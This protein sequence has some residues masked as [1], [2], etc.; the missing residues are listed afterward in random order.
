MHKVA[1]ETK[2]ESMK[3]VPSH[4]TVSSFDTKRI[5]QVIT[6]LEKCVSILKQGTIEWVSI[7]SFLPS[8]IYLSPVMDKYLLDLATCVYESIERIVGPY[9]FLKKHIQ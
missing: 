5:D 1:L 8:V 2:N 3:E 4:L 9:F 6:H 7:G